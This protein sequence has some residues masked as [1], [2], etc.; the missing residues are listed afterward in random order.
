MSWLKMTI[1][2][3]D[4]ALVAEIRYSVVYGNRDDYDMHGTS[5][6]TRT[7]FDVSLFKNECSTEVQS[8][9][10]YFFQWIHLS[11]HKWNSLLSF[12]YF[13]FKRPMTLLICII[14]GASHPFVV[15]IM[16]LLKEC[17]KTYL[18][19]MLASAFLHP[20]SDAI[21]ANILTTS[22]GNPLESSVMIGIFRQNRIRNLKDT[23]ILF[24]IYGD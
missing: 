24:K 13:S 8:I 3:F 2:G 15:F 6:D 10:D 5:C 16:S 4:S 12:I 23:H 20:Y 14:Y 21:V 9:D 17:F 19:S 7:Y 22:E 1:S 11:S 18:K